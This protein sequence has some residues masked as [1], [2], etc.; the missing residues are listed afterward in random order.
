MI[1]PQRDNLF[2]PLGRRTK[3]AIKW[4]RRF[5]WL[6]RM[7]EFNGALGILILMCLFKNMNTATAYIMRVA[8][9]NSYLSLLTA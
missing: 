8:V 9:S 7:L 5:Q 2:A 3:G 4:A 1:L 6:F